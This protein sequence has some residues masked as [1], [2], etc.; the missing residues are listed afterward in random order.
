MKEEKRGR[1]VAIGGL[2][3]QIILAASTLVLAAVSNSAAMFSLGMM[4]L[5]GLV[6]WI[7][8][9]VVFYVRQRAAMEAMEIEQL[10]SAGAGQGRIFEDEDRL[11][12]RPAAARERFVSRWVVPG[13]T[14]LL[15]AYYFGI[16]FWLLR[17]LEAPYDLKFLSATAV[18]VLLMA[19]GSFILSRISLGL[20]SVAAWRPL[21]GAGS[22][23]FIL[24]LFL[25]TAAITSFITVRGY[26]AEGRVDLL[27]AQ[28][29][30]LV[31]FVFAVE[32]VINL[33]LDL[34]RPR[35]PGQEPHPTYDSRLLNLLAQP[36]KVGHSLAEAL[37]YQFGFE[38]SSTW[39]YRLLSR[40]FLPLIVFAVIVLLLM[41]SIVI[42]HADQEAIVMRWGRIDTARE[43]L[44]PGMQ[45]KWPWPIETVRFYN[46]GDVK[47]FVV[48]AREDE[49]ARMPA[50]IEGRRNVLLWRESHQG[51][52]DLLVAMPSQRDVET[53]GQSRGVAL[54]NI[55]FVVQY[56]IRDVYVYGFR[57]KNPEVLLRDMAQ[58]ELVKLAASSTLVEGGGDG[59]V[60]DDGALRSVMTSGRG[61][62]A[63]LLRENLEKALRNLGPDGKGLGV[64]ILSV[65]LAAVHPPARAAEAFENVINSRLAM[66][67]QRM[68]AEGE[69]NAML[70]EVA[71]DP[72]AALLLA[73]DLEAQ[74]QLRELQ[75]YLTA[76]P[77][78]RQR[79]ETVLER[80]RL[81]ARQE[82]DWYQDQLADQQRI[83]RVRMADVQST[84]APL[85]LLRGGA[86]ASL[87][88]LRAAQRH[89][90]LLAALDE[91]A[92]DGQV[93]F[94]G[95]L[96]LVDDRVS[97][98]FESASGDAARM[99][100]VARAEQR[101][102]ELA[103]RTRAETFESRL[104]AY[105]AS[106]QLYRLDRILDVL[107]EQLPQIPAKYVTEVDVDKVEIRHDQTVRTNPLTSI[108]FAAP[109]GPADG[110]QD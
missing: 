63:P 39:F 29:F 32:I 27:A 66:V 82:V 52:Q 40:A 12:A 43:P 14:L 46:T 104:R 11:A 47:Q 100:A 13:A 61:R 84:A 79:F 56:R 15:A 71:G 58:A 83:G 109:Q 5:G 48:G 108:P 105:L 99:V 110:E 72:V 65:G 103:G 34:Y 70:A 54:A 59:P 106:P 94:A 38:V 51:E 7:L 91:D 77:P 35:M 36:S 44:K 37:N 3:V 89:A 80:Y 22:Y 21:R 62:L 78:Q 18:L 30:P 96:D 17:T 57:Y 74:R 2:I 4:L 23:M 6:L 101:T 95:S 45:L 9:A 42:V 102:L 33:I 25:L 50:T 8:V 92:A 87:V 24:T 98:L 31:M 97:E 69:A 88:L 86:N 81:Q 53:R 75:E 107:E 73:Q 85:E 19:F 90:A 28:A 60:A 1:N 10:E 20:G 49:F 67:Q 68:K 16:G 76:S 41:S 64:E 55:V 26:G 93:D